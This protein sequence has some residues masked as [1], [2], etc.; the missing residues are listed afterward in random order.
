MVFN[1]LAQAAPA[2]AGGEGGLLQMI[3][4]M[5]VVGL[6]FWL[7]V[8]RPQT[9]AQNTLKAKIAAMKRGDT[10]RTR[11]GLIGQMYKVEETEVILRVDLDDKVRVKVARDAIDDVRSGSSGTGDES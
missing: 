10:V 1:L 7:I 2:P 6:I 9:K 4:P 5:A 11:G 8:I 3:L